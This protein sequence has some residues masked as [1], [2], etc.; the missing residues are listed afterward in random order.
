MS[1][2]W[3][4]T[5][6]LTAWLTVHGKVTV[7]LSSVEFCMGGCKERIWALE[8]EESLLEAVARE[9]LEKA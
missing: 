1:P 3:G 7:P 4:S 9:L 6:G 5:L 8:A 2:R